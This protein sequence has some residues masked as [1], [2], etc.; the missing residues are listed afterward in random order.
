MAALDRAG[1]PLWESSDVWVRLAFTAGALLEQIN[2]HY[3][4]LM[5]DSRY[6]WRYLRAHRRPRRGSIGKAL[7]EM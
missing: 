1:V 3:H 2:Y 4:Q 5:Y 7:A 6:D